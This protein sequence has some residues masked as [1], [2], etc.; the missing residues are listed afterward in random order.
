MWV[1]LSFTWVW[2]WLIF[3]PS[4]LGLLPASH[5]TLLAFFPYPLWFFSN[6]SAPTSCLLSRSPS[7]LSCFQ[8]CGFFY[9]SNG[10]IIYFRTHSLSSATDRLSCMRFATQ[11]SGSMATLAVH[12]LRLFSSSNCLPSPTIDPASLLVSS[13]SSLT[14]YFRRSA[15]YHHHAAIYRNYRDLRTNRCFERGNKF[16]WK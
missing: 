1:F 3:P 2:G 10:M 5:S 15:P 13:T 14:D 11:H 7:F 12:D 8:D 6:T 16:S 4:G 9:N